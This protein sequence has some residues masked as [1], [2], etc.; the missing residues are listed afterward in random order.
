MAPRPTLLRAA[1]ALSSLLPPASAA[2]R[3]V[4]LPPSTASSAGRGRG[5]LGVPTTTA[6]LSSS[7]P[8]RRRRRRGLQST[9]PSALTT[10][11]GGTVPSPAVEFDVSS[12]SSGRE[13]ALTGL[14]VH[15]LTVGPDGTGAR[16]DRPCRVRVHTR[17]RGGGTDHDTAPGTASETAVGTPP[18]GGVGPYELVL[19]SSEVVCRGEGEETVVP[20][21]LFAAYRRSADVQAFDAPDGPAEAADAVGSEVSAIDAEDDGAGIVGFAT[22]SPGE[23]LSIYVAVSS[24]EGSS[25]EFQFDLVSTN[26]AGS[27]ASPSGTAASSDGLVLHE[28]RSILQGSAVDS[29]YP[30]GTAGSVDLEAVSPTTFDGSV[31]YVVLG[32]AAP[33][34]LPRDRQLLRLPRAGTGDVP[35]DVRAHLVVRRRVGGVRCAL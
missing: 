3:A 13:V 8:R 23:R 16:G 11:Y 21:G 27:D 26:G 10:G 35:R 14:S 7:T 24:P 32:G 34:S 1:L 12:T 28:G 17:R 33:P 4:D 2:G 18:P 6:R 25:G 15:V 29:G 5:I 22:L 9:S 19:D 31:R 20:D 30:A